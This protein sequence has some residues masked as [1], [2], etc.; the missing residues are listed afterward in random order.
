M[1]Q[2]IDVQNQELLWKMFHKIPNVITTDYDKKEDIFKNAVSTVYNN[3]PPGISHFSVQELQELNKQ[4]MKILLEYVNPSNR[5]PS[6][7]ESNVTP[8]QVF[9]TSEERTQRIFDEEQKQYE[10]MTAKPNVPTPSEL[11]QDKTEEDG[12]ITNMDELIAQYQEERN[13]DMTTYDP[14]PE[15]ITTPNKQESMKEIV[16]ALKKLEES[17]EN[18]KNAMAITETRVANIEKQMTFTE[19]KS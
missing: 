14:P 1:S 3:L 15:S 9:E 6:V 19:F 4:T 17:I 18:L 16:D 5:P 12:A 7:H 2:Y 11:F 13:Q 8:P 10:K